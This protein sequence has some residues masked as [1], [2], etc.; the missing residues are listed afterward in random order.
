MCPLFG[1]YVIRNNNESLKYPKFPKSCKVQYEKSIMKGGTF[2]QLSDV[3]NVSILGFNMYVIRNN[4]E[5]LK[6]PKVSKIF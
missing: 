6:Y 5:S 1:F 3:R 4:N 2:K